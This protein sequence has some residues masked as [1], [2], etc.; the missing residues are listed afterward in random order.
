MNFFMRLLFFKLE[1][2]IVGSLIHNIR[3]LF[4]SNAGLNF[5]Q[6]TLL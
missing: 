4:F 2:E 5:I 3:I 1:K 6:S